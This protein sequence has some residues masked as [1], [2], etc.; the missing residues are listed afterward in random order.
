MNLTAIL[1]VTI[2]AGIHASWNFI[3]KQEFPSSGFFLVANVFGSLLLSPIALLYAT[4]YAGFPGS[5][6]LLVL[7]TG[8]FQAL[9]CA[10]LAAA[11]R[12]GDLSSAYPLARS[13]PVI[14]VTIVAFIL[15]K[16]DTI[17][18]QCGIGI[19]FVVTGCFFVPLKSFTDIHLHNYIC[20]ACGFALLAAIGTA[21]Y[22]IVD[23]ES[24]ALLRENVETGS[25]I[26]LIT[27]LYA[28]LEAIATCLWLLLFVVSRKQGREQCLRVLHTRKRPA[29]L[30]GLGIYLTYTL[31]LIAMYLAR[32][33]SYVVGFRQL[34]IPIGVLMGVMFLKEPISRPKALG[35]AT[36]VLGLVLIGTG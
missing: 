29:F 25:G 36:L 5:V 7:L 35:V 20:R 14:V 15:G 26:V 4:H 32:N 2:S 17:S 24:L 33:V 21:G 9:Y 27:L 13:S 10:A 18:L 34:S 3:S 30:A 12:S 6:C 23:A 16:A 1:L 8:F 22:S 28:F 19:V 31:V 11:Y